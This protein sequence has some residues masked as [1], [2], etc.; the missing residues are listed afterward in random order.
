[1]V[2][3]IRVEVIGESALRQRLSKIPAKQLSVMEVALKLSA[4]E[5]RNEAIRSIQQGPATGA[6]Y[7]NHQASAP[8]EKPATDTGVLVSSIQSGLV[9]KTRGTVEAVAG[10]DLDYGI[11]Q[12]FGTQKMAARPWLG[13]A[14]EARKQSINARLLAAFKRGNRTP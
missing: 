6:V 7:G 11:H 12:E 13:P 14:F 3:P 10:T 1:M 4:L 2:N 5:I 8:G 9:T